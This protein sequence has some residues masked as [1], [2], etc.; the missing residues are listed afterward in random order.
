MQLK[1][2][3]P[4]AGEALVD[5]AGPLDC[6]TVPAIRKQLLGIVKKRASERVTINLAGVPDMD[7]AGIALLVET[8]KW[9]YRRHGLLRITGMNE[10]ARQLIRLA[11]LDDALGVEINGGGHPGG[12]VDLPHP[13]DP[14]LPADGT[15]P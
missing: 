5:L 10:K 14:F 2:V 13:I 7:S 8:V 6:A 11:H 3:E 15:S 9:I 1:L 4:R 12:A